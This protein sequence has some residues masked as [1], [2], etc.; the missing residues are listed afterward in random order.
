MNQIKPPRKP[1]YY[2][3]IFT[4]R[5]TIVIKLMIVVAF[6]FIQAVVSGLLVEYLD[7]NQQQLI[8]GKLFLLSST[9]LILVLIFFRIKK[10]RQI[11]RILKRRPSKIEL[12]TSGGFKTQ[13]AKAVFQTEFFNWRAM[14]EIQN[15]TIRPFSDQELIGQPAIPKTVSTEMIN[16][17]FYDVLVGLNRFA[18]L[19]VATAYYTVFEVKLRQNVPHLLFDSKVAKKQQFKS[20]YLSSQKFE[21]FVGLEKHFNLYSPKHHQIETLKFITPE[22]IESLIDLK[23]SD[24]ELVNDSLLCYAPLLEGDQL[25]DFRRRC[26]NLQVRLNDNLLPSYSLSKRTVSPFASRLLKKPT[27]NLIS[28]VFASLVGTF[29][30]ISASQEGLEIGIMYF[31]IVVPL[32][33]PLIFETISTIRQNKKIED[34][35]LKG[36]AISELKPPSRPTE[37]ILTMYFMLALILPFLIAIIFK[38]PGIIWALLFDKDNQRQSARNPIKEVREKI[39]PR[40]SKQKSEA[41]KRQTQSKDRK[42]KLEELFPVLLV[43]QRNLIPRTQAERDALRRKFKQISEE[44]TKANTDKGSAKA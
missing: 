35:F 31:L 22:V 25:K 14:S 43:D 44:S 7:P 33:A 4:P 13:A 29:V 2:S 15:V 36:E 28:F 40:L 42:L 5:R 34:Q 12:L 17:R 38:I 20:A 19:P 30:V 10:K 24:V 23:D 21:E 26:L 41:G 16:Y 18:L 6:V 27:T 39:N 32:I 37:Q 9:P 8:S 1:I 11:D 3:S